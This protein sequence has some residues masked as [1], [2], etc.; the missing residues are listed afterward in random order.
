MPSRIATAGF[1]PCTLAP[2]PVTM[3]AR[4][5]TEPTE[6]SMPEETITKVWPKAR[7]ATTAACTPT[8]SRFCV[9]RKTGLRT[10]MTTQ[11]RRRATSAPFCPSRA[12][13][14]APSSRVRSA[15]GVA[16]SAGTGGLDFLHGQ[17]HHGVL[18]CF[19]VGELS[20]DSSLCHHEDRSQMPSTS[21]RSDDTS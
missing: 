3:A 10:A 8:L 13:A 1:T 17:G 20:D 2:Y 12:W 14:R 21:G 16:V 4:A 19:F 7:M 18:G 11:S 15:Y 5:A 9:F 6:R